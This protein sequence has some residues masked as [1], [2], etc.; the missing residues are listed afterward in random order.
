MGIR[1][2][3]EMGDDLLRKKSKPVKEMTPRLAGI[4]QDML[5]TMY[6]ADGVGLAAPQVGI[7]KRMVVIDVSETRDQP[8][9]L[10]NPEIL[11]TEGEQTGMEGCL[12]VPGKH[13]KVTRAEKVKVRAQNQDM[14]FFELEGEGLLARCI[15]HEYDHLEGILYVDRKEGPLLDNEA[16]A[17]EAE[18]IDAAGETEQ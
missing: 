9:I 5:E 17:E 18:T 8:L 3:R 6:A 4:L 11:E 15:L 7:L 14:E 1:N 16:E 12:S 13:A 2:V 10:I